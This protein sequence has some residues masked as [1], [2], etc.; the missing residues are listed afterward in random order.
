[1]RPLA[2]KLP[3]TIQIRIQQFYPRAILPEGDM[4]RWVPFLVAEMG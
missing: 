4:L 1:M 3:A 2:V